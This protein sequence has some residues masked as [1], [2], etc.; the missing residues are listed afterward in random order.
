[1]NA[2]NCEGGSAQPSCRALGRALAARPLAGFSASTSE[3]AVPHRVDPTK[4]REGPRQVTV[5]EIT[6]RKQL[7]AMTEEGRESNVE[8]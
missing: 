6:S 8:N 3:S 4:T 1:V 7:E 5:R 2:V